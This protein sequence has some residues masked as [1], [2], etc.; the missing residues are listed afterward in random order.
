MEAKPLQGLR[1]CALRCGG[2][3]AKLESLDVE[4]LAKK[5]KCYSQNILWTLQINN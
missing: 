4:M 1:A 5:K 3:I 2:L